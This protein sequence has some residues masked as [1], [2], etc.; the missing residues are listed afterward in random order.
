MSEDKL[1]SFGALSYTCYGPCLQLKLNLALFKS[2]TLECFSIE[3]L[4]TKTNESHLKK[5]KCYKSRANKNSN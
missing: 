2:S 1:V 4:R 5:K 3:S